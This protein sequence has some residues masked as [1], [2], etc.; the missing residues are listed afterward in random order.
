MISGIVVNG[1]ATVSIVIRLADRSDMAIEFVIDTGFTGYL[2]LP[3]EIVALL[4]LP[5]RYEMLANLADNSEVRLPVYATTILWDG[6]EQE[7]RVFAK[8][9]RPLIGTA[10]LS[11]Y[12]LV[13]QFT[14]GGLVTIE[15]L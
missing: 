11:D 7:V 14:E 9:S 1:Q 15:K 8:G 3:P 6:E 2:Y 13:V 4:K 10:L 5:F 12:E